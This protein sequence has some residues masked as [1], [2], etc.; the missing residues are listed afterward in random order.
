M[1]ELD[2]DTAIEPVGEGRF[3]ASIT[4]RWS[5]GSAPNGG[6]LA[7]IAARAIA[8]VVPAP[9]PFSVTTHFLAV[10]R[11]GPA[12]VVTE[13]VRVGR[14]HSTAQ[15]KLVQDGREVLR[16]IAVFGDLSAIEG[17][18]ALTIEPPK[19][20][21][22]ESCERS[23]PAPS[24]ATIS[25]RVDMALAP[26]TSP[27][28]TGAHDERGELRGWVRLR[29]GREP[30]SLSL[31]FFADAFPPP[32]LSFSAV[33]TPWVPTLELTVHVRARPAPG[34]LRAWFRTRALI[35][36]YLEEDGELWDASGKLVAMSR[37]LA[38]IHRAR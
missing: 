1:S 21:P 24:A 18:T 8:A 20:P 32:V 36:G 23:R 31:V 4:D 9:D 17:P 13:I 15:A 37:Q 38:R 5:I 28:S 29:D 6:Y 7:M 26:G 25:D 30:D 35:D 12:E 14:G 27:W 34:M 22:S 33:R 3:R 10:A 16:T 19:L 11:P 2:T